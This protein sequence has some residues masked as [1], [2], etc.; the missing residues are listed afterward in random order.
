VAAHAADCKLLAG[1]VP[2]PLQGEELFNEVPDKIDATR[3]VASY[4][5]VLEKDPE[6]AVV[7]LFYGDPPLNSKT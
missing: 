1:L 4:S 7:K 2:G 6:R 3:A 5:L